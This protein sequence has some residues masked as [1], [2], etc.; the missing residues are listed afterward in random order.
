VFLVGS[1][2][3]GAAGKGSRSV[4]TFFVFESRWDG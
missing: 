2:T 4:T 1:A 3:V